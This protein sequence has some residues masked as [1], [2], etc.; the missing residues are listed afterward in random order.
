MQVRDHFA[1][2]QAC[3]HFSGSRGGLPEKPKKLG[4]AGVSAHFRRV[5]G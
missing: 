1:A 5:E 3:L 2:L 4:L